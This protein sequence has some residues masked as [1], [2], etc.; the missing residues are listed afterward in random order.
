M[1]RFSPGFMLI[2]SFLFLGFISSR[3]FAVDR[4]NNPPGPA[5]GPGTNWENP[6]GPQGGPGASPNRP[7][8]FEQ[9]LERH[10]NAQKGFDRNGDGI[11]DAKEKAK[12]KAR[13]NRNHPRRA[14]R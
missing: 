2:L 7:P 5:G 6:P 9:W 3:G 13:W 12:A 8:T 4:D 1:K 14:L 11:A 10:P